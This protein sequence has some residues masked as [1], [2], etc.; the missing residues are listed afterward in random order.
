MLNE[1]I[2]TFNYN[3]IDYI[4]KES[5]NEYKFYYE[6]NNELIELLDLNILEKLTTL[7]K[8]AMR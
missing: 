8:L 3:D 2:K 7:L 1:L 5:D 4:V 6:D